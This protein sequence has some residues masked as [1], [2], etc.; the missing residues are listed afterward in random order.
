ML[1]LAELLLLRL[2]QSLQLIWLLVLLLLLG[3]WCRC[4]WGGQDLAWERSLPF[5]THASHLFFCSSRLCLLAGPMLP[6][7]RMHRVFV[8][9]KL[10]CSLAV[11]LACVKSHPR[12]GGVLQ[13]GQRQATA[14]WYQLPCCASI[15]PESSGRRRSSQTAASAWRLY[16]CPARLSR[17]D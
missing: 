14:G 13:L 11:A 16:V 8:Q 9:K 6:C 7:V 1:L 17:I 2:G 4:Y 5:T 3:C 15:P 12:P 10:K